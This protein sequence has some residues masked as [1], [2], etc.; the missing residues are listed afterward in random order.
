MQD[1]LDGH[2]TVR[3]PVPAADLVARLARAIDME[4]ADMAIPL[5]KEADGRHRL[6]PVFCLMPVSAAASLRT[7]VD[8]GHR[9]IETWLT[10]QHL[11]QVPFE[12]HLRSR[13]STL[14]ELRAHETSSRPRE[15]ARPEPRRK[16]TP[17]TMPSLQSVIS[18]QS[19]YD[20][21][22]LP[23]AQANA[24]IADVIEPVHASSN[25]RSARRCRVCWPTT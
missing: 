1:G 19:D 14:D 6:Q 9:K 12:T 22:A 18:C 25:C 15:P 17:S 4:G 21:T 11:A 23:V 10:A 2:R 7:Y 5:V 16:S 13:T 8:A 3:Y 24:I 20:P